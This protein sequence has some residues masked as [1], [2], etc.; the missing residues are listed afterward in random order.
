MYIRLL[1]RLNYSALLSDNDM[2]WLADPLKYVAASLPYDVIMQADNAAWGADWSLWPDAT[3]PLLDHLFHKRGLL[4]GF[5][6]CGCFLLFRPRPDAL[7]LLNRWIESMVTHGYADSGDFHTMQ[8]HLNRVVYGILRE[9]DNEV[10]YG[11]VPP[12]KFPSGIMAFENDQLVVDKRDVVYVHANFGIGRA[13]KQ[14]RLQAAGLWAVNRSG[15]EGEG[16]MEGEG[17]QGEGEGEREEFGG[18]KGKWWLDAEAIAADNEDMKAE[19]EDARAAANNGKEGVSSIS[20][21]DAGSIH[22]SDGA[23]ISSSDSNSDDDA[24]SGGGDDAATTID[25]LS[26]LSVARAG[27]AGLKKFVRAAQ[28]LAVDGRIVLTTVNRGTGAANCT[29]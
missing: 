2:V 29:Q 25:L 10:N 12:R 18:V 4:F 1:L 21:S 13:S 7:H 15:E 3:S 17:V 28:R 6:A 27:R 20:N 11:L 19:E 5:Q 8:G 26:V 14:A 24:D 23:S 9:R 16:R 22:N